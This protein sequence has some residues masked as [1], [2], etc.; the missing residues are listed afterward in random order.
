[1]MGL[2]LHIRN[3]AAF[4][5]WAYVVLSFSI[6]G[7]GAYYTQPNTEEFALCQEP[8]DLGTSESVVHMLTHFDGRYFTNVLHAFNPLRFGWLSGYKLM[9]VVSTALLVAAMYALLALVLPLVRR[10]QRLLL[11]LVWVCLLFQLSVSLVTLLFWMAASFV[12]LYPWMLTCLW[13]WLY[14]QMQ[15]SVNSW[16]SLLL[17]SS[18]AVALVA[19][20]GLCEMFLSVNCLSLAACMFIAGYRKK[21]RVETGLLFLIL[22]FSVY[23]F[24]SSPGILVRAGQFKVERLSYLNIAVLVNALRDNLSVFSSLLF[25]PV[26]IAISVLLYLAFYRLFNIRFNRYVPGI[27]AGTLFT[28]YV[29]T[30]SYYIPTQ[31]NESIPVRIFASV[32]LLYIPAAVLVIWLPV[33]LLFSVATG[34]AV[35]YAALMVGLVGLVVGVFFYPAQNNCLLIVQEFRSGVLQRFD[36][37]FKDRY[38]LLHQ[39]AIRKDVC[40]RKAK[41]T[42]IS[43]Y[44]TSIYFGSDLLP[45]RAHPFSNESWE[46]YFQLDEVA[47]VGDTVIK[48]KL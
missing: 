30:L 11:V 24:V 20:L 10:Q 3:T 33:H 36:R 8:R 28:V 34:Y 43:F 25:H 46:E 14:I 41:V 16:R 17:F 9:P 13:L 4:F 21:Y 18:C 42:P 7:V 26:L 15:Q 31:N 1:M 32:S 23:L 38:R 37:E 29:M 27:I 35:R 44:P 40:Y 2:P 39:T 19:S 22:L 47:L 6:L 48:L 12:Y 45:N 5:L